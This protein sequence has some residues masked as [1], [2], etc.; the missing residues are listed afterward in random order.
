M[1]Q[2]MEADAARPLTAAGA[3]CQCTQALHDQ[4]LQGTFLLQLDEV[5]NVASNSRDRCGAART[6]RASGPD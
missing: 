4:V 5:I 2:C 3:P 6:A 1:Q